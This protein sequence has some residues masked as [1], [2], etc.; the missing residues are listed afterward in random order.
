MKTKMLLAIDI[1]NTN[2]SFGLFEGDKLKADFRLQTNIKSD[3]YKY[4]KLLMKELKILSNPVLDGVV[5]ASVVPK[6]QLCFKN[7]C[8]RMKAKKVLIVDEKVFTEMPI[9]CDNP[10]KVG[11][12]RLVN[13]FAA[14]EIYGYP[15]VIVDFGTATTFDVVSRNGE[16][17]GGAILPGI[18]MSANAL[19]RETA[20]LPFVRITK[21]AKFIG[22]NTID[23][24][25]SGVYYGAIGAIKIIFEGI[26]K[27]LHSSILTI[28]TGGLVNIL[29]KEDKK[30]FNYINPFLTLEGLRIIYKRYEKNNY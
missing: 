3:E 4:E 26:S 30:I 1:G 13:A 6:L 18:N 10:K 14:K 22:K 12:D 24:I 28:G 17:L 29:V 11:V 15:A 16:Y 21:P 23:A 5:I 25:K 20:K 19:H 27:E 8:K 2:I 7:I 9:L